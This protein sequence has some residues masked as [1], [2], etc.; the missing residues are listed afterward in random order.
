MR[1]IHVGNL[2]PNKYKLGQLV[3]FRSGGP[4]M[5]VI[6]TD[7]NDTYV[8]WFTEGEYRETVIHQYA[9]VAL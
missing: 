3:R 1:G 2:I 9:L 8:G 6:G 5:T 7:G 4:E